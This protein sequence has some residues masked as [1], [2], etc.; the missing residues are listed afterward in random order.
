MD[1]RRAQDEGVST[2]HAYGPVKSIAGWVVFACNVHGEAREDD[3]MDLFSDYG[4]VRRV[5]MGF[6]RRTGHGKGYALVEYDS[7]SEAQDAIN[8]LHGSDVMGRKIGVS[9]AFVKPTGPR[10]GY[11]RKV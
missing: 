11:R 3:V 9:W 2:N 1:D 5:K 8:H 4:V 7:Q 6:D 10:A